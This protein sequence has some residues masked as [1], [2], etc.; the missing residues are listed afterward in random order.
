MARRILREKGFVGLTRFIAREEIDGQDR[1]MWGSIHPALMGGEF[2]P[3][4]GAGEVEIAR[5]S[6]EST[7]NDQIS[8]RARITQ[9]GIR[10]SVVDEYDS[11]IRLPFDSS[12]APL[13]L[14]EMIRLID[15]AGYDADLYSGGLML[16]HL[17]ANF[18]LGG[19]LDELKGFVSIE[20]AYY[21]GLSAYY[22]RV[23]DQWFAER[24]SPEELCEQDDE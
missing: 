4:L 20:S 10:Y 8:V 17:N 23:L 12:E 14:D 18:D 6:L 3:R 16:F 24:R 1:R 21:P 22:R 5:I 9:G 2:L 19:E 15:G 13:T 11:V 7:T